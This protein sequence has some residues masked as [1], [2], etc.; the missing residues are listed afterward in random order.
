MGCSC[1]GTKTSESNSGVIAANKNI[2]RNQRENNNA[3]RNNDNTSNPAQN[4]PSY[5]PF[6]QSR[7][8]PT[9]N[10]KQLKE[11]VGEGVKKM[12]GYVCNI[13]K[14]ELL[15][16]R[17][18]FWSSRFEGDKETWETLRNLCEGDLEESQLKD[19]LT[20]I[21]ITTYSGCINVVYDN[22]GN[23]YEIPNYCIHEPLEWDIPKLKM[24]KPEEQEIKFLVRLEIEDLTI[25]TSNYCPVADLKLHICENFDF[26]K[27]SSYKQGEK[28]DS[29]R[30]RLF[31]YGKELKDSDLLYMHNID[32]GKIVMM[33]LRIIEKN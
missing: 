13:E 25:E 18:D 22:K 2:P 29:D 24:A 23:L 26:S 17:D 10:M 33:T 11:F 21:G 3:N 9:F 7:N 4:R 27:C 14:E 19:L 16:K 8:D 32:N 5:V 30:I 12:H 31:H 20:A 15:R 28:I 6:L 1:S